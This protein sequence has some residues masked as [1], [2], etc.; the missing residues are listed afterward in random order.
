VESQQRRYP[1][2]F[3]FSYIQGDG[4]EFDFGIDY[5]EC[6][7]VNFFRAQGA[8]EFTRYVCLYDFLNSQLT[9]TGLIRTKTLAEGADKCDFRFKIG[10]EPLNC[11]TLTPA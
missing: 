3:V 2:D 4:K 9:G 8:D 5:T 6:A 1:Q 10:R 7:I 11:R